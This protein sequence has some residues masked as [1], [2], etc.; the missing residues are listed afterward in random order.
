[1]KSGGDG[2]F[3]YFCRPGVPQDEGGAFREMG[4]YWF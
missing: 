1:M 4:L 3:S 2:N